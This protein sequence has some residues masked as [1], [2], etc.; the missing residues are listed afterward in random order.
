MEEGSSEDEND[1]QTDLF[2]HTR[3]NLAVCADHL[4]RDQSITFPVISILYTCRCHFLRVCS[5]S[6]QDLPSISSDSSS[7]EDT[8]GESSESGT[9]VFSNISWSKQASAMIMNGKTA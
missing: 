7:G 8:D 4:L 6:T 3:P 5:V 2:A 9:I 1:A